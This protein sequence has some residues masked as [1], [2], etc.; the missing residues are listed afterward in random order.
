MPDV[1]HEAYEQGLQELQRAHSRD[2]IRA[3]VAKAEGTEFDAITADTWREVAIS[4]QR[5][6]VQ[7][8]AALI[9]GVNIIQTGGA[10]ANFDWELRAKAG[11]TGLDL[12]YGEAASVA[13]FHKDFTPDKV[14]LSEAVA[15]ADRLKIVLAIK[16]NGAAGSYQARIYG[17]PLR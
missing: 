10:A 13:P 1:D 4:W 9:S 15:A 14:Y 5:C 17:R 16:P 7:T 6:G 8:V 11:G 12:I 2:A 3:I